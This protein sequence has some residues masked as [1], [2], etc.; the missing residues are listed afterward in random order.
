M[1]NLQSGSRPFR[2]AVLLT[3]LLLGMVTAASVSARP[4]PAYG[5][6]FASP[7]GMQPSPPSGYR[8][9]P[10]QPRPGAHV[11]AAFPTSQS[12]AAPVV[13]GY[14]RFRPRQPVGAAR[15]R[16]MDP[17]HAMMPPRY[18]PRHRGPVPSRLVTPSPAF[19]PGRHATVMPPPG[20]PMASRPANLP[21]YPWFPGYP[22]RPVAV[23]SPAFAHPAFAYP[24][25]PPQT[26]ARVFVA[27]HVYQ[28]R[29]FS[30]GFAPP[31]SGAPVV[32]P[33]RA[34]AVPRPAVVHVPRHGS[35]MTP[36]AYRFRPVARPPLAG[37]GNVYRS[38]GRSWRFR[39]VEPAPVAERQMPSMQWHQPT[40]RVVPTRA[41]RVDPL[42]HEAGGVAAATR[43]D[44]RVPRPGHAFLE[45]SRNRTGQVESSAA[46]VRPGMMQRLPFSG[47][48]PIPVGPQSRWRSARHTV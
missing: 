21:P 45:R 42:V 13:Q 16:P 9:R 6:A 43:T 12:A 22:R 38:P 28:Q 2:Q 25:L 10:W 19:F 7:P 31:A 32:A 29:L 14:Y 33:R 34:I 39:P 1:N 4:Y 18:A 26:W 24:P 36:G 15:S 8:F 48:A 41:N 5:P 3:L 47:G 17:H 44:G 11:P 23:P 27:P 37:A 35:T 40:A 30:N 20:F 46:A